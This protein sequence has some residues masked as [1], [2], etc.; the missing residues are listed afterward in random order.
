[1]QA[2]VVA[3]G[4]VPPES[5]AV[6]PVSIPVWWRSQ[7]LHHLQD[8]IWC[9]VCLAVAGLRAASDGDSWSF[10]CRYYKLA[11]SP[12]ASAEFADRRC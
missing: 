3:H 5:D 7:L 10:T 8:L 4:R 12:A 1:M 6:L 2:V 9:V 11:L